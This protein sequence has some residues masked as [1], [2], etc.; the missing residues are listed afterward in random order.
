[1]IGNYVQTYCKIFPLF[2]FLLYILKC[3]LVVQC[4]S[5]TFFPYATNELKGHECET[6]NNPADF[7]LDVIYQYEES[8]EQPGGG[9]GKGI[10]LPVPSKNQ[11]GDLE[12][13]EGIKWRAILP[14][15]WWRVSGIAVEG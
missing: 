11:E 15:V 1:M 6:Y 3:I 5:I 13:V 2:Q 4:Y 14:C 8:C 9:K 7:F 10:S 12:A